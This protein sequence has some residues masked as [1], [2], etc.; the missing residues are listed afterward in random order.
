VNEHHYPPPYFRKM[1]ALNKQGTDPLMELPKPKP[2]PMTVEQFATAMEDGMVVLD[3]RSPEAIAGALIP[4]SLA[5][6]LPM[7][8]AFAG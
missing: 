5:I 1:E 8:P 3:T 4:G 7:V 6:P 2:K